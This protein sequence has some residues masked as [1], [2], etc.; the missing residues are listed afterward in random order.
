MAGELEFDAAASNVD[1]T[2]PGTALAI[3]SNATYGTTGVSWPAP[4]PTPQWASSADTEGSLLA[5]VKHENRSIGLNVD[6]MSVQG[7]RD[8]EAKLTKIHR[9]GGTLKWT[10][11]NSEVVIFDLLTVDSFEPT[12]DPG[13]FINSGAFCSVAIAMTAKPYGRGASTTLTTHTATTGAPLVFTETGIK[14]DIPAVGHLRI[15]NTSTTK[16]VVYWGAQSRYYDAASTAAIFYE[17]EDGFNSGGSD[18]VGP[19]GASGGGTNKVVQHLNVGT[20]GSLSYF[21]SPSGGSTIV[22][23]G[24]YRVFAR[25]QADA[26]NT[27][28]CSARLSYLRD[29]TGS[30]VDRD[31]VPVATSGGSA[32]V[33]SWVIVDL[34]MVS[35]NPATSPATANWQ[36]KMYVKSTV[37]TDDFYWDWVALFPVSEGYGRGKFNTTLGSGG[38]VD[39]GSTA[40]YYLFNSTATLWG[41]LGLYEGDYFKIPV[42]GLESRTL[43]LICMLAGASSGNLTDELVD[44]PNIDAIAAQITYTP[45]YLVVPTV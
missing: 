26:A 18:A 20:T 27:G 37:A 35:I 9:E 12:F 16:T 13:Y 7:L 45:R 8:L 25:V 10:L 30:Q 6:V 39:I 42:A 2:N 17:A 28:I 24:T 31:W 38:Q 43:R 44:A 32:I 40:T 4:S 14:G 36:A 11:P 19:S 23:V 5:S 29:F 33:G 15:T 22:N 34:G 21:V 1:G 41:S 3:L